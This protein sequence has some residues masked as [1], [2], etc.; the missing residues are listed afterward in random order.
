MAA[1]AGVTLD[2]IVIEIE[3]SAS[4]ATASIDKLSTSLRNLRESVSGGFGNLKKLATYMEQLKQ[5]SKGFKQV[6]D[7]LSNL[8]SLGKS[9]ADLTN[10]PDP[11]NLKGTVKALKDLSDTFSKIDSGSLENITRVSNELAKSL[12]PLAD[13]LESVAKGYGAIQALADKYGV[14]VTK[15][16]DTNKKVTVDTGKL[17]DVMRVTKNVIGQ[18][19]KFFTG[20][21]NLNTKPLTKMTKKITKMGLALLG[22]R[23]IFTAT[24][25]AISEYLALDQELADGFQNIW[26]A[27]GAQLAPALEYVLYLFTQFAR[28][29]YSII[30][31]LTGIDLIARANAKAMDKWAKSSAKT[32]G[33]L[34]KFDDLNV[35]DF[36][37][38]AGD[39]KL[40]DLEEIDLSPIQ[41]IINWVRKLKAEIKEA[42]NTGEWAG[43]GEV[44]A[45]G[46][47]DGMRKINEGILRD[48]LKKV[49]D[50]FGEFLTGAFNELDGSELGKTFQ[51][52]ITFLPDT[53]TSFLNAVPWATVGIKL[54][55]AIAE[56]DAKEIVN[57]IMG[58]TKTA[59]IGVIEI[60]KQ[61]DWKTVARKIYEAVKAVFRNI[62][63]ILDAI[64][65]GD[66][67]AAIRDAISSI[68]WDDIKNFLDSIVVTISNI[69]ND[70]GNGLFG[71]GKDSDQ[72][73][74]T[75]GKWGVGILTFVVILKKLI[76]VFSVT[77][78]ATDTFTKGKLFDKLGN[79][80]SMIVIFGGLALVLKEVA[81]VL[82]AFASLGDKSGEAIALIAVLFSTMGLAVGIMANS[83]S[84]MDWKAVASG[85]VILGGLALVF[86]TLTHVL[87][88]FG[89]SGLSFLSVFGLLLTT[90]GTIVG[91]MTAV[92]LL[93]PGM[94]AGLGPFAIVIAAILA[95]LAVMAV[96]LPP[97]LNAVGKFVET[98][99]PFLIEALQIVANLIVD[100]L[101]ALGDVLPPVIRAVGSLVGEIFGGIALVVDTV[102]N[103]F[104]KV[105]NAIGTL[106]ER[107]FN[108]IIN[109]IVRLGKAINSFV[110]D[111]IKAITKLI[112]FIISGVEFFING[113]IK[114]INGLSSGLR[115]IGNKLFE[116]IGVD[117]TFN[118][119][120]EVSLSRFAPKLET[121]TNEIPYEGLY[122]LHPGEAVVPKKYNPALGNG[123]ND[124]MNEKLNTLI[125]IV[126]NMSFTNVVNVGNETLYRKQQ[127][128]N[129]QQNDKY[130]TTVN[131]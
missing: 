48:K 126:N 67:G 105:L 108:A 82:K 81:E 111:T 14:S 78:K 15:I 31:A 115:K 27:L 16:A 46:I 35:V 12:T 114:G 79:L 29:I 128:Y 64:P 68:T 10:I 23:T 94:T 89:E 97:I 9:L 118:A 69:L 76:S 109:F 101:Y 88:A 58:P 5:T 3:S 74:V 66:I 21:M 121:G 112:N 102:G 65:W 103:T 117:V 72:G 19:W 92:K 13:K 43:V 98:V 73:L 85:I 106:V 113:I 100:I 56:L 47:N 86:E 50:N 18:T 124:E 107:I 99:A 33:N 52:I 125:D 1:N 70:L 96:T 53:L 51:N 116:L 127:K 44:F 59:I 24:R 2:T 39:N 104:V 119:I 36:G 4:N 22:T 41:K 131:I 130:G 54:K 129:K 71:L 57:S 63:E 62:K 6:T 83:F 45:D 95:T 91:L 122:H 37:K 55:E 8:S 60:L 32:L 90:L 34:Q 7:N 110:D 42:W 49:A 38:G 11:K 20:F 123:G 61:Q 84:G 26:R 40:I 28:V 80:A 77:K 17:K 87:T 75:L 30:K 93:G 120:P 25:K